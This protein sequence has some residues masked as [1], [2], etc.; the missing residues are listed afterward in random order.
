MNHSDE[1]RDPREDALSRALHAQAETVRPAGDGLMAIRGRIE[2]R[3]SRT[4][5]VV[6]T[7]SAAAVVATVTA[8]VASGAL[9]GPKR[10]LQPTAL[11]DVTLASSTTPAVPKQAPKHAVQQTT[12]PAP[13]ATT[14]VGRTVPTV[15]VASPVAKVTGAPVSTVTSI[16]ASDASPAGPAP[17]WPFANAIAAAKWQK[18]APASDWHSDAVSTAE[19]FLD[20][21][22]L[23]GVTLTGKLVPGA[24][25]DTTTVTFAQSVGTL[26]PASFAT[27]ELSQWGKGARAPWGVVSVSSPGLAVGAPTAG[28][29][30][31]G[32]L[33]VSY[34]TLATVSDAGEQV[35]VTASLYAAGSNDVLAQTSLP[36]AAGSSLSTNG[37]TGP[38]YVVMT[39]RVSGGSTVDVEGLAVVPVVL[40]S[41]PAQTST[42]PPPAAAT[43]VALVGGK[44][45]VIDAG[46][47]AV[48]RTLAPA[49]TDVTEVAV[50]DDRQWVYFLRDG[51]GC[52]GTV[53]RA[54]LDGTGTP[55]QFSTY[56]SGLSTFGIAGPGAP[57]MSYVYTPCT[58]GQQTLFF[59]HGSEGPGPQNISSTSR[60]PDVRT[61][62]ISPDGKQASAFVRT[63]MMGNVWTFDLTAVPPAGSRGGGGPTMDAHTTPAACSTG[64]E[65]VGET[66]DAQGDLV[67]VRANGAQLE[68]VTDVNGT[69]KTL[70][71][72]TASSQLAT[73]D[74]DPTGT[75]YLLT[76][77][78]SKG[79][80]WTG[81]G[82]PT[83][84]AGSV[85]DASW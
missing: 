70:F 51:S 26:P 74:I 79:W 85:T 77:G 80:L 23:P 78:V 38:G 10:T 16:V 33:H 18:T 60:P 15:A 73:L 30:V 35:T 31:A 50:S 52:G 21:L 67:L 24:N 28:A 49:A 63:G 34:S 6:P 13:V 39:D 48:V 12:V 4:R 56:L 41:G 37:A 45:E 83:P 61:V 84:I 3:R 54:P 81:S 7:A 25:A 55:A 59:F 72:V 8:V 40:V 29:S 71:S 68:V 76:D 2:R 32:T 47:G 65:C 1:P 27:V 43:Y 53:W 66:Y 44:I 20:S 82:Q 22:K 75:R 69:V 57:W 17:V 14:A 19:H 62:A 42:A 36:T 58:G 64:L 46:T 11:G 5:W 9:T